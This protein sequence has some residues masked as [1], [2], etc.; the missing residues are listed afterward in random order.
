MTSLPIRPL[1][2]AALASIA[3][4]AL[5]DSSR[6][7]ADD[8][9]WRAECGGCHAAFPPALLTAPAW[10]QVMGALDRHYGTDAS[11]DAATAREIASFLERNAGDARRGAPPAAVKVATG[12]QAPPPLPRLAD[13]PWFARE[14]R[15]IPAS[16]IARRDVG[17]LANC[18]A[19]HPA[20]DR[21]DFSERA[22]RV[23]R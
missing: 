22:V 16:T 11:L 1:L 17:S 5:A 7:A 13:S 20:A 3:T 6:L 15:K 12:V 18:G 19:C 2:F 4:G 8:P 9:R 14:H 10:R 23:P 21:G